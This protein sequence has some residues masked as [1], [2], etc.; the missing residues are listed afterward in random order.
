MELLRLDRQ[1]PGPR[2][3]LLPGLSPPSPSVAA[4]QFARKPG[5]ASAVFEGMSVE[6]LG[7]DGGY[8]MFDVGQF[9]YDRRPFLYVRPID[10]VLGFP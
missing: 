4:P 3:R 9:A 5:G 2:A 7:E 8:R 10:S 6:K 1:A